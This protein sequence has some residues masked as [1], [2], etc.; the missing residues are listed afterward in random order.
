MGVSAEFLPEFDSEMSATRRTLERIPENKLAWKPHDKSMPLG[1]LAGH[2]AELVGMG[3]I[4][5]KEDSLDFAAR[6]PGELGSKPT[7]A[8]SQKH[9][10]EL[11][12][13]RVSNARAAIASASDEHWSKNWKLSAGDR[14]FYE[15]PRMGAMRR[16]VMNHVIHHRSQLGLPAVKRRAGAV[17]IRAFGG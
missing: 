11:F 8:E 7:V 1:R 3:V 4:V 17:G 15:G 5:M 2:I 6:R 12:D 9:V 16:M 14:K 10:L 13:R